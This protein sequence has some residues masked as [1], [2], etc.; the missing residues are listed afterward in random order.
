LKN[1]Q[2]EVSKEIKASPER[3]YGILSDYHEGHPHILPRQYFKK[4]TV[5]EGGKGAGTV[6][7]ISMKVMGM[8]RQ[9]KMEISEPEPGRVLME[10][11]PDSAMVTTFTVDSLDGGPKS[12][13]T[14]KT[15]FEPGSGLRGL[16]DRL[17]N[18][19]VMR[20]IYQDELNLLEEYTQAKANS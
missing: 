15:N 5:L 6:I 3:I 16:M 12:R 19:P 1:V 11:D 4:L 13:V 9:F 7:D 10:A 8:Q 14:I 20:R 17:L 2:V 18:P